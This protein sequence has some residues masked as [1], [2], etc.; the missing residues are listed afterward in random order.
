MVAYDIRIFVILTV[1]K[2]VKQ[3]GGNMYLHDFSQGQNVK[4]VIVFMY[5]VK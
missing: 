5:V 3:S 1:M 4:V 2:V